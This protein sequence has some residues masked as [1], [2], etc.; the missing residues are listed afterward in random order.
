MKT[1]EKQL[2]MGLLL[3]GA[4]S[5]CVVVPPRAAPVVVKPAPVVVRPAPVVVTPVYGYSGDYGRRPWR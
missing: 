2:V 3:S 1:H 5:A 4:L